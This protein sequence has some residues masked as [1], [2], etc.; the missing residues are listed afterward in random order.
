MKKRAAIY[1]RISDD[2][3]GLGLG[4]KRQEEDC[5]ALAERMEGKL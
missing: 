5:L 2:R 1:C 4:V 3:E